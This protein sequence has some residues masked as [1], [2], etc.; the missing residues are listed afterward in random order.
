MKSESEVRSMTK[1]TRELTE[2]Q[3]EFLRKFIERLPDNDLNTKLTLAVFDAC[4]GCADEREW[5]LIDRSLKGA[6]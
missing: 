2:R 1:S 5:A 4:H 6:W 3:E